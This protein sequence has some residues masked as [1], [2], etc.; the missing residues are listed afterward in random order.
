MHRRMIPRAH[1]NLAATIRVM[2]PLLAF[3]ALTAS[4]VYAQ[5]SGGSLD[6]VLRQMESVGKSFG[7]FKAHFLQKNYRA[8]L[9]EFDAPDSGEFYYARAKDGSALLR[10]EVTKPG[11]R[12]LTI[13][14]GIAVIY[15]PEIKQASMV[16]LGKNKD[17][18][19]YLAIGLG[20]SPGKLRENFDIKYQGVETVSGAP[21]SVLVLK[22]KN[23][24]AAAMFTTITLW[25]KKATGVP[26]Q[27]KLQEPNGDYLLVDFTEEKLNTAISASLFEQQLPKGVEILRLQ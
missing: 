14:G 11:R 7:N 22:P 24:A 10:Q 2:I 5:S 4:S 18:V 17:K 3:V 9:K 21:C 1:E 6:Q 26:I 20:Q 25:I 15:Q 12:I 13:K 8:I 27:H 16:N 19:E 23:P